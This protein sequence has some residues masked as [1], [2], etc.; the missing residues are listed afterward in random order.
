[1]NNN[2]TINLLIKQTTDFDLS[3]YGLS[4]INEL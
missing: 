4:D 3:D 2:S 1:M